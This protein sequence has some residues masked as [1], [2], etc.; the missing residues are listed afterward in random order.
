[1]EKEWLFVVM[2]ERGSEMQKFH[3][4][5]LSLREYCLISYDYW[6]NLKVTNTVAKNKK[7]T[8]THSSRPTLG[9]SLL[10]VSLVLLFCKNHSWVDRIQVCRIAAKPKGTIIDVW[11]FVCC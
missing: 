4:C 7:A 6:I 5:T 11:G 3:F 2:G 1:M 9:E 10:H 8:C